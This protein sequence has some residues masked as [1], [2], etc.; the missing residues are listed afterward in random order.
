MG[1]FDARS[2]LLGFDTPTAP[3]SMVFGGSMFAPKS[4]SMCAPESD[5]AAFACCS[6]VSVGFALSASLLPPPPPAVMDFHRRKCRSRR[7]QASSSLRVRAS[8]SLRLR[9]RPSCSR[10]FRFRPSSSRRFR[11]SCSRIGW[12]NNFCAGL[13]PPFTSAILLGISFACSIR[14]CPN[15]TSDPAGST[16]AL[17][18]SVRLVS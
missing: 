10:R 12:P 16:P 18:F 15:E 8:S 4:G 6:G 17:F 2:D 7:V 13:C 1:G 14:I 3:G 9:F 11:A 5:I